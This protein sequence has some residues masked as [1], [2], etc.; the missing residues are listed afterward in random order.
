MSDE[1]VFR[2]PV[3]SIQDKLLKIDKND[4]FLR[5]KEMVLSLFEEHMDDWFNDETVKNPFWWEF[6]LEMHWYPIFVTPNRWLA[7]AFVTALNMHL[8]I[9]D[10]EKGKYKDIVLES[11]ADLE[12]EDNL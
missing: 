3:M 8:F 9:S 1:Y 5:L 12:G 7:D 2:I 11:L 4:E 6:D 10:F